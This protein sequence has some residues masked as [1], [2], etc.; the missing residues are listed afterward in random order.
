M[1]FHNHE[2]NSIIFS[3]LSLESKCSISLQESVI[4]III[5]KKKNNASQKGNNVHPEIF[6]GVNKQ[7]NTRQQLA[8]TKLNNCFRLKSI[9]RDS[10]LDSCNLSSI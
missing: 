6:L 5:I 3:W 9:V 1:Y 8:K 4:K 10:R 7:Y 2:Y